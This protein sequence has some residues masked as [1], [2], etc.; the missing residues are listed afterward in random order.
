MRTYEQGTPESGE[1]FSIKIVAN[2]PYLLFGKVPITVQTIEPDAQGK[3]WTLLAGDVD[4][5]QEQQPVALC[6]CGSSKN[7]PYCDGS[8][9]A[10][11]WSGE[12]TA[13]RAPLLDDARTI[14]GP[15]V[16]LTDN[17]S[18]CAFARFCEAQGDTW[19]QTQQS[20]E[21]KMRSLAIRTSKHCLSGRL[22]VWD[23]ATG[24]PFEPKLSPAIGL[25]QDPAIGV[26]GPI[27]VQGGIAVIAPDGFTFEL[28]NRVALC[29]CGQSSNKP[30]CDG[31]H[32]TAKYH[33]H[34]K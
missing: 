5:G 29:R 20:D 25:V 21:P 26:S 32:F 10:A 6:R 4:Y 11:Y 3:P 1:K 9:Q 13:N 30:F 33:D 18:Y 22:K 23:N 31:T 8:H 19:N 17:E 27:W 2:G 16:S 34:I 12:L 7:A 14:Q 24:E 15:T 28:R